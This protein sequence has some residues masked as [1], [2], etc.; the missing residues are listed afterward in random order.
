MKIE[1]NSIKISKTLFGIL[2][3]LI[4]LHLIL[5]KICCRT[6]FKSLSIQDISKKSQ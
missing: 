1:I 4:D 3:I 5:N 2:L 6:L